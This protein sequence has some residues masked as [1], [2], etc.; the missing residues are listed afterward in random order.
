M[1]GI[2][3]AVL[4]MAGS[5]QALLAFIYGR[6]RAVGICKNAAQ[7]KFVTENLVRAVKTLG[8]APDRRPPKPAEVVAWEQRRSLGGTPTVPKAGAPTVPKAGAPTSG[9]QPA[10]P[11][12]PMAGSFAPPSVF[13]VAAQA[14]SSAMPPGLAAFGSAGLR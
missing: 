8:L 9:S 5:G 1:W 6:K 14:D 13:T 2:E 3:T 12:P 10:P 4:F 11:A 7:K